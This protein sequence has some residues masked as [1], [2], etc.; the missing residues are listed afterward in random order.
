VDLGGCD[1]VGGVAL[2]GDVA[3]DGG[4]EQGAEQGGAERPADLLG[5]VHRGRGDAGVGRVDAEGSAVEC[6]GEHHPD[7][8]PE[9]RQ[10]G[11]DVKPVAGVDVDLGEQQHPGRSERHSGGD[12]DLAS[13][14]REQ[15][16]ASE[17][18]RQDDAGGHRQKRET[19]RDG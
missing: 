13:E 3:G 16:R 14:P 1:D 17:R 19:G 9:E 11:G 15:Q 2:A 7:P 4:G 10:A 8:D 12:D 18:G 6:G 5:G